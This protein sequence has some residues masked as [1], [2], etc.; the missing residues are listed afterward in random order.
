M[1]LQAGDVLWLKGHPLASQRLRQYPGLKLLGEAP[2][3]LSAPHTSLIEVILSSDFPGLGEPLKTLKFWE[4]YQAR[5]LAISRGGNHLT[6]ELDEVKLALGDAML[7]EA[8]RVLSSSI[9]SAKI[10]FWSALWPTSRR[11]TFAK[12]RGR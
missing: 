10:S 4:R 2:T 5:V 1:I 12:R 6:Q 8:G 11:R 3:P 9:V 7:L